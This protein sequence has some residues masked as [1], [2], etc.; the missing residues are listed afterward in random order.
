MQFDSII[1]KARKREIKKNIIFNRLRKIYLYY[2]KDQN[3]LETYWIFINI[4]LMH[5]K[6]PI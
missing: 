2:T 5:D 6:I 1:L 3:L 4:F